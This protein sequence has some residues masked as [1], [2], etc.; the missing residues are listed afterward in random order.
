MNDRIL[1]LRDRNR[2]LIFF[3]TKRHKLVAKLE[4]GERVDDYS[5]DGDELVIRSVSG[6]FYKIS[7]PFSP[8]ARNGDF[9]FY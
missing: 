3:D 1:I 9:L 8:K 7:L 4:I 5:V 2:K 6:D